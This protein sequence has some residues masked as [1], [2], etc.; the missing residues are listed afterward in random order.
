MNAE[1]WD[2]NHHA[3]SD[4]REGTY[5]LVWGQAVSRHA[6]ALPSDPDEATI[7]RFLGGDREA[8]ELLFERY[9]P[10]VYNIVRGVLDSEDDAND[11]TQEVF[12]QVYRS[13]HR[14]RRGSRFTTWL[15]RIALNRAL[16]AA[17]SHRR[18]RWVSFG[19]TLDNKADPDGD[20]AQDVEARSAEDEVRRVLAGMDPKHRDVLVLRYLQDMDIEEIAEVL[21][22]SVGAAKVRLFRA[23]QKFRERYDQ[24]IGRHERE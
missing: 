9:G 19:E 3:M 14:F 13:L 12:L 24:V 21:G 18:R 20:P 5:P 17:R 15:Y 1:R 10:Y 11:V 6:A 23:R 16:D 8:F 22:C 7:A 2:G 4:A